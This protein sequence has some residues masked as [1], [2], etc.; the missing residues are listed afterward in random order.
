MKSRDSGYYN[1]GATTGP[2]WFNDVV[3]RV[4]SRSLLERR[5]LLCAFEVL[6]R[7]CSVWNEDCYD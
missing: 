4:F 1:V 6:M 5:V 7:M 2:S 3:S